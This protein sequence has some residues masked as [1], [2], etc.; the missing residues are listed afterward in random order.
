[1][2][3]LPKFT[4]ITICLNESKNIRRTCE[5]IASQTFK[6]KEW[7]VLDGASTDDTLEI[8]SE[9]DT[10]ITHLVSEPDD[11]I[12][13]AMNKGI[14]ISRGEYIIFMNGGDV[15]ATN[16]ALKIVAAAPQSDL[17][18]GDIFLENIGAE[19]V[20]Y[21]TQIEEN[22]LLKNMLPHQATFFRRNLFYKFGIY[23]TSYKIAA[24]YELFA[25]LLEYGKVSHYHIPKPL[26]VFDQSGISSSEKFRRIRKKENHRV[27]MKYFP[28]YRWSFKALRQSIRDAIEFT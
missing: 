24:D 13:H 12:Y 8:L 1:M 11:G 21:P 14:G 25:R 19:R 27:R 26:A 10:N 3:D 6:D 23:D 15:F 22:F 20:Q 2:S 17:I 7:I 16:E 28:R 18:Y 4:I 9:F 5:S